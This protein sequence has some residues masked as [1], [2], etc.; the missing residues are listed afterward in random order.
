MRYYVGFYTSQPEIVLRTLSGEKLISKIEASRRLFP[1]TERLDWILDWYDSLETGGMFVPHQEVLAIPRRVS[2]LDET[3][4]VMFLDEFHMSQVLLNAQNKTL[5]VRFFNT[6]KDVTLP[7]RFYYIDHR[8]RLGSGKDRE[9]DVLGAAGHEQWVCQSKWVTGNKIGISV[10]RTLATQADRVREKTDTSVIRMWLF[11]H[12]GLTPKAKGFAKK[13]GILWSSRKE[14]DA[15]LEH[16]GL[17][18]LPDSGGERGADQLFH[19]HS[20][21]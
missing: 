19:L 8:V 6:G 17:R 18:T 5:P 1:F 14:F 7:R 11:A 4:I 2:D 13:Y 21:P 3:S 16:V 9:I 15:L 20:G 10:L 12:E